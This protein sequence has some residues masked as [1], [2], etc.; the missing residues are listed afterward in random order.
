MKKHSTLL[1]L[2]AFTTLSVLIVFAS[3]PDS[4]AP[5]KKKHK[6]ELPSYEE[7][8]QDGDL[9]FQISQSAQCVAVQAATK[10][11][12]S[13][14]GI[15]FKEDGKWMVLEAVQPV[16]FVSLSKWI[17][18]GKESHYVVKR[19]KESA[20]VLTDQML[21]KMKDEGKSHIG[22]NYDLT[23]EWNDKKMYCSEL[24]WKI[25]KRTTGIEI[26]KLEKLADFDLTNSI[27]KPIVAQRYGNEIPFDETVISPISIMKSE[28][29]I[30]V[31]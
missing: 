9:I 18:S 16:R 14:C 6:Y 7:D 10:S 29:L 22:K 11:S 8:I 12:Y 5:V 4:H 2:F 21:A 27:V 30:T 19:L 31:N 24:I 23:F 15:I 28:A 20:T 1:A 3:Y 26:G 25:Y 13:H 17:E